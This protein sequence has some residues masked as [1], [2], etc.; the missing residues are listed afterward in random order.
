MVEDDEADDVLV[1]VLLKGDALGW[2]GEFVGF[3]SGDADVVA[4]CY[5]RSAILLYDYEKLGP[6]ILPSYFF[7]NASLSSVGQPW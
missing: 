3:F 5:R 2:I 1:F 6:F 7:H 4:V